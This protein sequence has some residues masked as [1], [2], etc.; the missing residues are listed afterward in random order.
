MADDVAEKIELRWAIGA[1]KV[2]SIAN[3]RNYSHIVDYRFIIIIIY[4]GLNR[5]LMYFY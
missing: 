5:G 3:L 4:I 2:R 1:L